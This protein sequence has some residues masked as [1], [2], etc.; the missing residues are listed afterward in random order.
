M[1][2]LEFHFVFTI[3]QTILFFLLGKYWKPSKKFSMIF[4][5]QILL[6][7]L[8]IVWTTPWDNY[9]LYKDVW[10]YGQDRVI[11]TIGYVPY[12]EY[13]FFIIQCFFTGGF[14]YLVQHFVGYK[15]LNK[16]DEASKTHLILPLVSAILFALGVFCLTT[17]SGFYLGLILAWVGPVF[18]V[19]QYF[20]SDILWK[21]RKLY[22]GTLLTSSIYLCFAD[23]YAIWDGIWKISETYTIGVNFGV[24]PLEEALFFFCTNIMLLQ[25]LILFS[26]P[27]MRA[28]VTHLPVFNKLVGKK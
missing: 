2:Y 26:H 15:N 17:T 13:F 19:Q 11:G 3:P 7:L 6:M 24:L 28:R 9:L 12:E 20:G 8:A 18:L 21:N 23:A 14:F 10:W 1:T 4:K 22:F 27:Q 25:G 5:G 16:E